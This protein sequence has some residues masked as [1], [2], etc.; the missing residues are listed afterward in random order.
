MNWP[1][2]PVGAAQTPMNSA[3]IALMKRCASVETVSFGYTAAPKDVPPTVKKI[4]SPSPNNDP[5]LK[6][7]DPA[8]I[9]TVARWKLPPE[10]TRFNAKKTPE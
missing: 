5:R 6:P 3:L 9:V 2:V 4:A 1:A 8:E 10:R 7:L